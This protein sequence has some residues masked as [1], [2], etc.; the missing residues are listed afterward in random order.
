MSRLVIVASDSAGL[1]S[2]AA[3]ATSDPFKD[4]LIQISEESDFTISQSTTLPTNALFVVP[5]TCSIEIPAGVVLVVQPDLYDVPNGDLGSV[6]H[7]DGEVAIA[8]SVQP[9][10]P[11]SITAAIAPA[12][13]EVAATIGTVASPGALRSLDV[14][15]GTVVYAE[16]YF[17]GGD[18]AE[19]LFLYRDAPLWPSDNG[20]SIPVSGKS[21]RFERLK[22][23]RYRVDVTEYGA[24]PGK[25]YAQQ[26]GGVQEALAKAI[27][28]G[29]EELY[30]P[31]G[32]YQITQPIVLPYTTQG[33]AIVGQSVTHA[34]I[35]AMDDME[36]II[37]VSVGRNE[38]G[39]DASWATA[40]SFRDL[41]IEKLDLFG[42]GKAT[43]GFLLRGV[44]QSRIV[45]V[46]TR[47]AAQYGFRLDDYVIG[48]TFSGI[49]AK[50][51]GVGGL[52]ADGP[53]GCNSNMFTD[54]CYF[55]Y[56]GNPPENTGH[57]IYW[58]GQN[59]YGNTFDCCRIESNYKGFVFRS[60]SN[61]PNVSFAV[62]GCY[63]ANKSY[64]LDFVGYN[65]NKSPHHD[66]SGNFISPYVLSGAS[67][68]W[69]RFSG[70]DSSVIER[71]RGGSKWN[72][73]TYGLTN[74][75]IEKNGYVVTNALAD[76]PWPAEE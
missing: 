21:G 1:V 63:M 48:N 41:R 28:I 2:A 57:G 30:F 54:Q 70:I 9:M 16:G 32:N 31:N 7:G 13:I 19:G 42:A 39:D 24:I 74:C 3:I 50:D 68:R 35:W 34:S 18:G 58:G 12:A 56:N 11:N 52:R 6:F 27:A 64:D 15:D 23:G 45:D 71:N 25:S 73:D 43:H 4:W 75:T 61:G 46:R 60:Q 47:Y 53:V 44:Y 49:Q 62:R 22:R 55:Q 17:T 66:L 14:A 51:N 26:T 59:H 69:G 40:I 8:E 37:K 36:A 20:Y 67:S 65:A 38:A 72:I 5:G 29:A 10:R 33:F 76:D